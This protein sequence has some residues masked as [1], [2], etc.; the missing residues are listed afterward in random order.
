[1]VQKRDLIGKSE[2]LAIIIITLLEVT[3]L[4]VK[5]GVYEVKT[6]YTMIIIVFILTVFFVY[7]NVPPLLMSLLF[8][9]RSKVILTNTTP[10]DT[11]HIETTTTDI[12]HIETTPMDIITE[13]THIETISMDTTPMYTHT[14]TT[15]TDTAPI[16]TIDNNINNTYIKVDSTN[17]DNFLGNKNK[18]KEKNKLNIA[19]KYIIE[20]FTGLCSEEEIKNIY[21]AIKAYS[22]GETDFLNYSSISVKN[23]K[24]LDL[25]HFGWNIWNHFRVGE[26]DVIAKLLKII[27]AEKFSRTSIKTIKSH[28]K[29][30]EKKG[31]IIIKEDLSKL[32]E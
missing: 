3:Y 32:N 14:N 16:E 24:V 8:F 2:K 1:M 5:F 13:T 17:K 25:Y 26:Q 27:F 15:T 4:M 28:L 22:N 9:I 11:T 10:T 21:A 18:N 7:L 30:D 6:I 31:R 29:D 20:T 23:L 12:P 19:E